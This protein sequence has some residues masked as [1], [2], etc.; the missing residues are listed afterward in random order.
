MNASHNGRL[1][2]A[3]T[4]ARELYRLGARQVWLFGSL[5]MGRVQD[6]HSDIDLAV[7]GLP[8]YHLGMA[9]LLVRAATG[10][11]TDIVTLEDATPEMRASVRR[12]CLPLDPVRESCAVRATG[13]AVPRPI[14]HYQRRIDAVRAELSACG[15]RSVLDLGCGEGHLLAS[16]AGDSRFV[17]LGG[18]DMDAHALAKARASVGAAAGTSRN[19]PAV[20]LWLG[21]IVHRD[22]RLLGYEADTALEVIEHLE[23]PQLEAFGEVTFGFARPRIVIVT[24]PNA[25]YNVVW[26]FQGRRHADHRFEWGRAEF[27]AWAD[28]AAL[29][30]GYVP[31][32]QG[33]GLIHP[34]HGAPTQMAV[35]VR[36]S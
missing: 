23:S 28:S 30:Y 19:R 15:S 20:D 32:F 24:T 25:E 35:F 11:Y 17:R 13:E 33:I 27:V 2:R 34:D 26:G 29:R 22:E 6:G 10:C 16:L 14:T 4:G 3:E 36:L 18:V 12:S 9:K 31:T 8:R 7:V 1:E 5:A 21:L